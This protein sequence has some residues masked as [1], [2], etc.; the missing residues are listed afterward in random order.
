M[1]FTYFIEP[2]KIVRRFFNQL[3]WENT[4]SKICLTFDDGP[5]AEPTEKILK[6]L[7]QYK[8]KAIFFLTG[9]NVV[10]NFSLVDEI[11]SEGHF[12]ANHSYN[13]SKKMVWMNKYDISNEI[14]N[15]EILLMGKENFLKIFRPP[16]GI[17]NLRMYREIKSLHYKIMMWSLLT[18]DYLVDF[19]IVKRNLDKHLQS[20]SIVV[21][22]NNPKSLNI[23][24]RSLDYTFNLIY[25][26]GYAVGSTFNF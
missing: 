4:E 8:A 22:H 17:I 16:Y 24:E 14:L 20:N 7:Q 5:F 1:K 9:R 18:E 19:E 21:F 25:K 3:I 11:T 15:T 26:R 10:S 23:I 12:I 13:H 2:P 6:S